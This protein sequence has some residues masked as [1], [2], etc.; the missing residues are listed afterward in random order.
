MN[1]LQIFITRDLKPDSSF[2]QMLEA[3]GWQVYGESLV[4][5]SEESIQ[6]VPETD[7]IFF[8]SGHAVVYFWEG[9]R[10]I[11][12]RLP[13]HTKL[14]TLGKGTATKLTELGYKASFVGTGKPQEVARQ[15]VAIAEGQTVLFPRALHSRM[16]IQKE[17]DGKIVVHDLVVYKNVLRTD[18]EIPRAKYLVFT[19]PMNA[20]AF[21]QRYSSTE[22]VMIAIG[23]T[24][25]AAL[26]TLDQPHAWVAESPS[27]EHLAELIIGLEKNIKK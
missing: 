18:F 22:G 24:T 16:S 21:F 3:E 5:F 6:V 19:S 10:K 9:L 8:Y 23:D 13:V 26:H 7:W 27:E 25:A 17:L 15:F 11:D 20:K 2:R 4:A 1:Q 14:A 12:V